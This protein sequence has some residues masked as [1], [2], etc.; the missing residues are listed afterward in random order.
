MQKKMRGKKQ[1]RVVPESKV[2]SR[3]C[4]Q[5]REKKIFPLDFFFS[6]SL[7]FTKFQKKKKKAEWDAG[8][9]RAPRPYAKRTKRA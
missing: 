6:L 3:L 4:E 8:C 2:A 1:E 7:S 5:S 9:Q